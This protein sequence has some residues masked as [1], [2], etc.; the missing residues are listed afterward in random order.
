MLLDMKAESDT[1]TPLKLGGQKNS[2]LLTVVAWR[3]ALGIIALLWLVLGLANFGFLA[4]FLAHAFP[5]QLLFASLLLDL[6][7]AAGTLIIVLAI[8]F[9]QRTH[10]ETIKDLGWRR[11]TTKKAVII[12]VIFG[13][14]WTALSYSRG[15]SFF[16]LSWERPVMMVIGLFLAFGEELGRGFFMENLRRGGI[17][18]WIQVVGSGL[19]MGGYHGIVGLHYSLL[20]AISSA[21]LFG[22]LSVIFVVGK[23]SLTPTY[24]AHAMVHLL[25]DP[26]LTM[27]ILH[28]VLSYH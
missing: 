28:G 23:R 1:D 14:L 19:L 24:T 9:W 27:G 21:V 8:I 20:Y 25:G 2:S 17:P 18:T 4:Q 10:K 13:L 22:L 26:V 12:A 3:N 16:A 5:H 11:P 15:G 6:G 7:F